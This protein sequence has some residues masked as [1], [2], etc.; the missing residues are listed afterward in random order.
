MSRH[1]CTDV[2]TINEVNEFVQQYFAETPAV[3]T[4]ITLFDDKDDVLSSCWVNIYF[5]GRLLFTVS[6]VEQM[7]D[8]A[9]AFYTMHQALFSAPTDAQ[10]QDMEYQ[11]QESA[12]SRRNGYGAE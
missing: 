10:M 12:E 1:V 11:S 8:I 6:S 9:S 5:D 2:A 4:E 7:Q 3:S